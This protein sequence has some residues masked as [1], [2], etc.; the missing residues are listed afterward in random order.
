MRRQLLTLF[1]LLTGLAAIGAPA[2]AGMSE[3]LAARVQ[4][5]SQAEAATHGDECRE[6][7]KSRQPV[8]R[9]TSP[10]IP[11]GFE[12]LHVAVPSVMVGSDY[13]LE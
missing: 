8:A 11:G 13:A 6:A 3:L 1:A 12:L 10:G 5:G 4:S 2:S 9:P 7:E